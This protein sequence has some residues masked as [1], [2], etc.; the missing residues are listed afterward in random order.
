MANIRQQSVYIP[1]TQ[2]WDPVQIYNADLESPEALR[3]LLVRMY[4]QLGQMATAVNYKDTG[5]YT[6]IETINGQQY[7]SNPAYNSSTG[8]QASPRNVFRKVLNFGALP[9]TTTKTMAHG[10]VCNTSTTFTRIYGCASD[11]TGFN[12]IP[13]PY[14]STTNAAN[15]VELKV[16]ATNVTVIAGTNRSSFNITY[17]V[18]EYLQN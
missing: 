4:Q 13:L 9:N 7:F 1:T 18:L 12:Y 2:I 8:I 16:N 14:A 3:E 17:I 5:I 10:I 11:T 6:T 15:C